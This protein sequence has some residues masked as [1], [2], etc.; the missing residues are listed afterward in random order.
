MNLREVRKFNN[1][2]SSAS[3]A[4]LQLHPFAGR[5]ELFRFIRDRAKKVERVASSRLSGRCYTIMYDNKKFC[6]N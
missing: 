5:E 1:V 2:S 6:K 4:T 3:N